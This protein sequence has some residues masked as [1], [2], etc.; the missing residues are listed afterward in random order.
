MPTAWY[1]PP[2]HIPKA[3]IGNLGGAF[4][5]LL[6]V[7][8]SIAWLI[9]LPQLLAAEQEPL[10]QWPVVASL[11]DLGDHTEIV[12]T[13][14]LSP[15]NPTLLESLVLGAVEE[16]RSDDWTTV[17]RL[18]QPLQMDFP[19]GTSLEVRDAAGSAR[20]D[21]TT[22]DLG[23]QRAR[24]FEGGATWLV[25][26]KVVSTDPPVILAEYHFGGTREDY[27]RELAR[28]VPAIYLG[29]CFFASVGV[30]VIFLALRRVL[31]AVA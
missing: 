28:V 1:P 14:V 25:T 12:A 20:G 11:D 27:L 30:F 17:E 13:G 7:V 19:D 5:G 16:R 26:G 10:E 22:I 6:F 21:F 15:D 23:D 2:M 31:R 9:F 18:E 29:A 8:A 3:I 24:G 4:L